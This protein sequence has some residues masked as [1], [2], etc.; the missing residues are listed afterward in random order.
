MKT[1]TTLRSF[2]AR[3]GGRFVEVWAPLAQGRWSVSGTN[4]RA[5]AD[6]LVV[7]IEDHFRQASHVSH[8]CRPTLTLALSILGQRPAIIV[9]TGSSAWG[10]NSSLLFDAYVNSFGGRFETVDIRLQPSLTLRG[11]CTKRTR[12]HC[13]DSVAFLRTWADRQ[14]TNLDLVYLDSWDVDWA[15]PIPSAMHGLAEFLAIEGQLRPGSLLLVDDTPA[16]ASVMRRVQPR[17]VGAFEQGMAKHGFPPGKGALI[18]LLLEGT[19]RGKLLAHDYQA[20]WQF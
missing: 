4:R 13:Q 16:D 15:D 5:K 10:T 6:D 19:G 2:L 1:N 7:M 18:K 12:L 3:A 20:L 17:H 11:Q 9:E 14:H 8:P